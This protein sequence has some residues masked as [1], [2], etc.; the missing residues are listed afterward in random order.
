MKDNKPASSSVGSLY[1]TQNLEQKNRVSAL[2]KSSSV[3]TILRDVRVKDRL[4][5]K[6]FEALERRL[7]PQNKMCRPCKGEGYKN[8]GDTCALC[9]G[10]GFVVEDADMRAVELVLAPKF[11]KTQINVNADLDGMSTTDLLTMIEGI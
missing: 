8:D 1:E 4:E 11:P 3:T 10:N 9:Q 7:E 5:K 6:A 2:Q